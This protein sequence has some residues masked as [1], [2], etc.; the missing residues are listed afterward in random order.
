MNMLPSRMA[1]RCAGIYVRISDDKAEDAA[2]VARQEADC[3]ALA[4]RQGWTVGEVYVENDTSAYKRKTVRLPDGSTALRVVRPAFRQM[5]DALACGALDAVVGY[6]LDRIARDPRDLEDL[7]D[8]VE[9]HKIPTRAVTGSLDLGN[10]AGITMARV[11]VA[12]AN[13]SSRDSSRRVARKHLELAEQG[14]TG[15]GGIRSFGYG[16]D[17]ITVNEDEAEVLRQIANRLLSGSSLVAVAQWLNDSGV[18]TVRGGKWQNRSVHAVITKPRVAGLRVHRGEIV[19]EA[20]WP[21]VIG[22]DTWERLLLVLA[23][24]AQGSTN[25]MQRW[26]SSL[27]R[28]GKCGHPLTGSQQGGGRGPRYWCATPRGGCG[29]IGVDAHK[30]EAHVEKLLMAYLSRSDVLDDLRA[31]TS[32]RSVDQAREEA[33]ADEAQLQELAGL[34]ASR[35]LTT[36][37]YLRARKDI[38]E[39]LARS[40]SLVRAAL[41]GAVR[42]LVAGDVRQAWRGYVPAQRREVARAV[43]PSGIRVDPSAHGGLK[44]F[45]SRRLVPLDWTETASDTPGL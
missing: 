31:V 19:G 23:A 33:R 43:L 41:P 42:E 28:C 25:T 20:A 38:E 7:I 13:K 32:S 3:R 11:M 35:A 22:R 5:L 4:E 30:S 15:G 14:K 12:I 18:P 44:G 2:G 29:R 10:D 37:E 9:S 21:A 8:V 17:G 16:R 1:V 6:D 39:R 26:L 36:P 45:D 40:R 24:R 34:W 27:L